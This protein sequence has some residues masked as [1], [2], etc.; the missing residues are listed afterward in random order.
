MQTRLN[1][2][3]TRIT[4][5]VG[6]MLIGL[7][8]QSQVAVNGKLSMTTQMFLDEMRGVI[9]FDAPADHLMFS[10]HQEEC[11]AIERPF[12]SPEIVNGKTCVAAFV[13]VDGESAVSQLEAMG[14]V[15]ECRF[16]AGTL[17]TTLIP[18]DMIEQ[19]A[20]LPCVTRVN[21]SPVMQT[22]SDQSRH[23]TNVD[24]V[25]TL[26]SDAI[27]AGLDKHYDGT[28]VVLGVI[29]RGIDF[30]HPA[31]RDKD[32]NTRIK[33]AY[34]SRTEY[35]NIDALTTDNANID[36]GTHTSAIAGGSSVIVN[37][38]E[39][40]VTDDHSHATYGGM[41]PGA[42]LYLAGLGNM[43]ATSI[44]N[45]FQLM[46]NYAAQEGKP[47]IVSNSYS[48][49]YG[50]HDGTSDFSDVIAEYFGDEHPNNFCVFATGN[51]ANAAD[52]AEGGG[53]YI[54]GTASSTAPLRSIL[55]C[56]YLANAGKGYFYYGYLADAWCRSLG[57]TEMGCTVHVL[58]AHTGEILTTSTVIPTGARTEIP[59]LGDYYSG[60]LYVY[61]DYVTADKTELMLFSSNLKSLS[62]DEERN[63]D[64][65]LAVEFF[66]TTGSAVI[67]VWGAG[68]GYFTDFLTT[69]GHD[70]VCGTDD[71]SAGTLSTDPN[72][73]A[74][75]SYVSR[76]E[77][78]SNALGD[79]S[80][81]SSY[82][83]AGAGP[84]GVQ[85]P[86]ISA[87]G[88]VVV[89]A[90]NHY[91][92][93]NYTPV[94]NNALAPYDAMSGTSMATP[95]VAGI[96][97]L[98]MQVASECDLSFTLTDIKDIMAQTAIRDE[99]VNNGPH[100]SHFGNGKIDALA[101]INYIL[102]YYHQTQIHEVG[103]VNHNG[104]VDINDVTT[105]IGYVL[106]VGSEICTECADIAENGEIDINDV[107]ALINKI[108]G[109]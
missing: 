40:T 81:F 6:L 21:V 30:Q 59:G 20:A 61:K 58:D 90:V 65:T 66:P 8:L 82:A 109:K 64:Y 31:F 73:I 77:A 86:W 84:L 107:T 71:M 5:L 10:T 63:S 49:L 43:T 69:E 72:V 2:S 93:R 75:G 39:V 41:A 80:D 25:L 46:S 79:I 23:V 11:R 96:L 32:G 105:L 42:D 62:Y 95:T 91:V 53:F 60:I 98:W 4:L 57:D 78:G 85:L 103:D 47:L 38:N 70:W 100:A 27:G 97:A 88:Q 16:K 36:H 3:L 26:S 56:S 22:E 35:S 37:G 17:L 51:D 68:S 52:P 33:R 29:D 83:V 28:G 13:H 76:V 106:G 87:P 101:G 108:L 9:S 67:D 14:V 34:V 74:V 18:V 104:V 55:R 1:T 15:V 89:S 24:D 99:W 44:C 7:T 12:A 45:A 94:V 50:P 48:W 92:T 19:V 54:S 102:N